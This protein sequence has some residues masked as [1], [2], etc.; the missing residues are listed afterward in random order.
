MSQLDLSLRPAIFKGGS[1][2]IDNSTYETVQECD[3]KAFYRI[4]YKRELCGRANPLN[5]GGAV[6]AALDCRYRAGGFAQDSLNEQCQNGI[7]Y[8]NE[9]P[10]DDWRTAELLVE[11]MKGYARQYI[12]EDFTLVATKDPEG[13]VH[14]FVEV[15]FA[16]PLGTIKLDTPLLLPNLMMDH[17]L[18]GAPM[19]MYKRIAMENVGE[20]KLQEFT[21]IPVVWTGKIDLVIQHNGEYW[22]AD[23][24]TTSMFGDSYFKQYQ[25]SSQFMGYK[26][27]LE[28]MLGVEI[29]GVL[30]NVL[31]V[32]KPTKTGKNCTYHRQYMSIP[33][34]MVEDWKANTLYQLTE[35]FSSLQNGYL[36]MR[37]TSCRTKWHR[38]CEYLGVCTLPAAQREMYLMTGDFQPVTWSPLR[39]N[40]D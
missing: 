5:F 9:N 26:W 15:P 40:E 16:V 30:I 38:D 39:E 1:F 12:V 17:L 21:E 28:Q 23:H 35:F 4:V 37:T 31:A 25:I 22:I 7:A 29:A 34:H 24:K 18:E 8:L 13:V 19:E 2:F 36:P 33:G 11:V 6:H 27:A 10:T 3:R 14:P 32:R 20:L